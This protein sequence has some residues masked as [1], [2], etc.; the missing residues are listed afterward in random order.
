[1][2]AGEDRPDT[3]IAMLSERLGHRFA[4]PELLALALTHS[5]LSKARRDRHE[6]NERL[7]FLGDRVL[8]LVV[9]EILIARFPTESEGDLAYRHA[10]LVRRD[11]LAQVARSVGL[12]AFMRMSR[13][14]DDG[15][16][17]DNPGLLADCCEAVIAALYL[18]GGFAVARRFIRDQW[19][20]MVEERR[21]PPKDDKTR[22]QEWAQGRGLPLPGYREVGR[23]GPAHAPQFT[24]EVT[25]EGEAPARGSGASKRMAEQAAAQALL[26]RLGLSHG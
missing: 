18:D 15:G 14:E 9:A 6:T 23:E 24:I 20:D 8:G 26:E 19:A 4:R 3:A 11:A 7:E 1:M 10:G 25:V 13:G 22:L 16:G 2:A 17:R 5:S 21:D 12:G